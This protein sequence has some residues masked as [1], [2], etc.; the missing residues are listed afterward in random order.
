MR[1]TESRLVARRLARLHDELVDHAVPL[2]IDTAAGR[3]LLEEVDYAR[4]PPV[5]EGRIPPY[6]A[7]VSFGTRPQWEKLS[8]PTK[9]MSDDIDLTL[10]RSLA[11]GRSSFVVRGTGGKQGI[12]IF[13][14]SLESEASA[15]RLRA[16]TGAFVVQRVRDG[17]VRVCGP[18]GVVSWEGVEWR[19]KPLAEQHAAQVRRVVPQLDAEV[20][21][22]LMELCVHWLS[23]GQVGATLVVALRGPARLLHY[24]DHSAATTPPPLSVACRDH[25]PALRSVLAQR[26][27]A[28]LVDPDWTVAA[29]D[30]GLSWSD[31][32]DRMVASVGGMR[33]TSARRFSFEEPDAVV[34]VVSQDGPATVFSDGTPV[35]EVRADPCLSGFPLARLSAVDPDRDGETTVTC[36]HCERVLL[37]DQTR[38]E[39]WDGGPERLPCPVCGTTLSLDAYRSAIRGVVKP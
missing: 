20:L 25:F 7:I 22:G 5:H 4:F 29:L 34:F 37:V 13:D 36:P 33:H 32:A 16:E 31:R 18:D 1:E 15:A 12:V 11:D 38:F 17:L 10:L 39:D 23:A 14:R 3:L 2:P 21:A 24:L 28:A 19:F 26:D 27:R 9:L 30:V 35:T 6:G 8:A